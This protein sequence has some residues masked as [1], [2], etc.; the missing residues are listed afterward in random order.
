MH[1]RSPRGRRFGGAVALLVL[2]P[3]I[4]WSLSGCETL[5]ALP[6]V[7]IAGTIEGVSLNQTGKTV[8]DHI[9]S[10]I[11]GDDCSVLRYTKG[12]KYC[13]TEA[14][15]AREEAIQRRAY[16]GSCYRTRGSVTCYTEADAQHTS[17]TAIYNP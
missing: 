16:D 1:P 12:G 9:A 17:E 8:S 5:A 7:A 10:G 14:E 13:L 11:T 2:T 4:A 15:L 6:P 3:A